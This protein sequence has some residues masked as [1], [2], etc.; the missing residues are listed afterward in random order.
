MKQPQLFIRI[1]SDRYAPIEAPIEGEPLYAWD[2][3]SQRILPYFISCPSEPLRRAKGCESS[4]G[5][6]YTRRV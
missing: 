4:R 3:E 5:T 2:D 1:G 6:N